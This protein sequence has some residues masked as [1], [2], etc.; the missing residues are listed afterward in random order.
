MR[1]LRQIEIRRTIINVTE[2]V[3]RRFGP[4]IIVTIGNKNINFSGREIPAKYLRDT[5]NNPVDRATAKANYRKAVMNNVKTKIQ[6]WANTDTLVHIQEYGYNVETL[7]PSSA[8]PDYIRFIDSFG[9]QIKNGILGIFIEGRVDI[10]SAVMQESIVKDLKD[11]AL[12]LRETVIDTFNE[13]YVKEW[14][15]TRGLSD[16]TAKLE[17][18]PTDKSSEQ[19]DATIGKLH[20]EIVKNFAQAGYEVPDNILE[21]L[22]LTNMKSLPPEHIVKKG[23]SEE[24]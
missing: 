6:N 11:V 9:R 10:T 17:F 21:K 4:Q 18:L 22:D 7:N 8:L 14:F 19:I 2:L 13:E 15:T 24:S 1:M 12:D 23:K 20:S 16:G 3:I 5:D